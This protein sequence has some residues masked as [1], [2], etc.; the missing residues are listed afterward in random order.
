[1]GGQPILVGC[2]RTGLEEAY[3]AGF[4]NR[5]TTERVTI[6][7]K[8]TS[9]KMRRMLAKQVRDKEA[10]ETAS[11]REAIEEAADRMAAREA[12]ME[13]GDAGRY[14][15]TVMKDHHFVYPDLWLNIFL[16]GPVE[17]RGGFAQLFVR[18]GSKLVTDIDDA[19]L[20]VFTG[21]ADVDPIYYGESPHPKTWAEPDRDVADIA[22]YA[23]CYANG[24]PML[25]ICRGSQFLHVMNGGKLWQHVDNHTGDHSMLDLQEKRVIDRVSSTHHQMVRENVEGGMEVLAT[26]RKSN[27]RWYNDKKENQGP[28]P[29][30]EAYFYRET[31][32]L[33]IQ[34]HPEYADYNA[35]AIWAL[36]KINEYVLM[37]LDMEWLGSRR[38]MV[39]ELLERRKADRK[40]GKPDETPDF[41]KVKAN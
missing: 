26:A 31:C 40:K 41:L 18:T 37:N 13:A 7:T 22:T 9:A 10:A 1:M 23:Y 35:F 19:D 16:T 36:N 8:A 25:G 2:S 15:I 27:R 12:A 21:G 3:E 17:D 11:A 32:C 28:H 14:T 33:G 4:R 20:V 6:V 30:I 5:L 38:R 29:D 24:I 34:G 39:P